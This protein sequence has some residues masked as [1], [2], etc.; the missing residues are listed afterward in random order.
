MRGRR[1]RDSVAVPVAVSNRFHDNGDNMNKAVC[2]A[3]AILATASAFASPAN[4]AEIKVIASN[5][6]KE[7]FH[8]LVPQF[9]KQ[10]GH[11]VNTIWGGTVDIVKRV[12]SGEALDIAIIPDAR[13]D[14]LIKQGKLAR[15]VDFVKSAIGVA[16]RPG[17]PRPDVSSGETLKA[18]LLAAKSIVLSS[19]PSSVYL[20]GLFKQMGIADTLKPKIKQLAPGLSVGEALAGGEGD[21]GFTQISEFL[22]IKGIEYVG[23]LPADIQHV[24][25]FSMGVP[26]APPAP[27]A[28]NALIKYLTSPQAAPAIKHAGMEPAK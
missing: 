2:I 14:E 19:G 28:A 20:A 26:A 21:V 1:I 9:E 6:V 17:A 24:T 8:D 11:K 7:A 22:T 5:A 23:P 25:V 4:A 12:A 15:R 27:D 13:I 16:I 18:S 3:A 10:T